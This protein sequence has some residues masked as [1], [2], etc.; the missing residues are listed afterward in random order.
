MIQSSDFIE[1][2]KGV[3]TRKTDGYAVT[4]LTKKV[5]KTY[6]SDSIQDL[7]LLSPGFSLK[8]DLLNPNSDQ[9]KKKYVRIR[10]TY[11][12]PF[13]DRGSKTVDTAFVPIVDFIAYP[14][15]AY[16][17]ELFSRCGS[18]EDF[19]R[20]EHEYVYGKPLLQEEPIVIKKPLH[21]PLTIEDKLQQLGLDITQLHFLA[22]LMTANVFRGKTGTGIHIPGLPPTQSLSILSALLYETHGEHID[23]A[24]NGLLTNYD[25][26]CAAAVY[27]DNTVHLA[28]KRGMNVV[29]LSELYDYK[30]MRVILQSNL[31]ALK[32]RISSFKNQASSILINHLTEKAS[33]A[34]S[35][36]V[37][38]F[39][40]KKRQEKMA[41]LQE[42]SDSLKRIKAMT[43]V[44]QLIEELN[45]TMANDE[46]GDIIKSYESTQLQIS[47]LEKIITDFDQSL[48]DKDISQQAAK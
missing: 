47:T 35:I 39:A 43:E 24:R 2:E 20:K 9:S 14:E 4:F 45:T 17:S 16:N 31:D 41:L 28:E 7:E 32:N 40:S 6:V 42:T 48:I 3:Y 33:E 25:N 46:S 15:I 12:S 38:L 1:C 22:G 37:S 30:N 44:S 11:G 27:D 34:N 5:N 23:K 18:Q 13:G 21:I 36:K 10:Y 8:I 19:E 26:N 29:K